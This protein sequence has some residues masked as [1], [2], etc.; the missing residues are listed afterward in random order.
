M[1]PCLLSLEFST[2]QGSVALYR[3]GLVVAEI[4]DDRPSP[5]ARIWSLIEGVLAESGQD[6][7]TIGAI[8][9]GAGPGGFTGVRLACG[10]AQGLGLTLNVPLFPISTLESLLPRVTVPRVVVALDA[11][12]DQVYLAAYE[13]RE[14]HWQSLLPPQLC[15]PDS[16]P[17]LPGHDWWGAGSGAEAWTTRLTTRWGSHWQGTLPGLIPHATQIAHLAFPRWQHHQGIHA[18]MAQPIYLRQRVALTRAERGL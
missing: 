4:L 3:E 13:R 1:K 10:I 8:A 5:S 6:W 15:S 11:R 12:M 2:T 16:L 9:Y 18:A 14:E 17:D 7:S